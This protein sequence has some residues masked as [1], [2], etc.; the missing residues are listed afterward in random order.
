MKSDALLGKDLKQKVKEIVGTCQSMGILVGS[1]P[2]P[3]A[4]KEINAGKY[5]SQISSGK[6][7][8]SAEEQAKLNEEKKHLQEEVKKHHDDALKKA[9]AIVADLA[10]KDNKIIRKKLAEEGITESVINEVAPEAKEKKK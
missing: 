9:Q 1:V 5:D 7:E 2:A 4:I 3:E 10:G 6:T 8:I